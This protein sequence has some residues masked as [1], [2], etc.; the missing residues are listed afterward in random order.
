MCTTQSLVSRASSATHRLIDLSHPVS[1][2]PGGRVLM[3]EN[4][5]PELGLGADP[6]TRMWAHEVC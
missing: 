3:P 5:L 6:E 4:L 2:L 1:L